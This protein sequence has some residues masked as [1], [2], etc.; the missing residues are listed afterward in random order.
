MSCLGV[1]ACLKVNTQALGRGALRKKVD[2]LPLLLTSEQ[3]TGRA[4]RRPFTRSV[5]TIQYP[6]HI[7]TKP[8]LVHDSPASRTEYPKQPCLSIPKFWKALN[9]GKCGSSESLES[10]Q[11][12]R[13][14]LLPPLWGGVHI[15]VCFLPIYSGR[16]VRWM[17]QP[18]SHSRKAARDFPSTFL[19]RG[20]P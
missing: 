13:V 14:L 10:L 11:N 7:Y 3:H 12:M 18:G 17:Y 4:C 6:N 8:L 9:V 19:L 2:S 20:V 15:Y 16:Q 1:G 5:L